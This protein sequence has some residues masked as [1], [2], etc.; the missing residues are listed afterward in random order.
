MAEITSVITVYTM[1]VNF[2]VQL[3]VFWSCVMVFF[4]II[5]SFIVL[6]EMGFDI[7]YESCNQ[8][9]NLGAIEIVRDPVWLHV[10]FPNVLARRIC[11][12]IKR[13]FD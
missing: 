3:I 10:H 2:P 13:F 5:L 12:T 7:I 8:R 9:E 6:H 4:I 1:L 11:L